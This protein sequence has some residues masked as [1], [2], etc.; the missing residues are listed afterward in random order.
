MNN[1]FKAFAGVVLTI[2]ALVGAAWAFDK[3]YTPREVMEMMVSDLQQN[4]M[5]SKKNI[6][7]QNAQQWLWFWQMK[8]EEYTAI[9]SRE[10]SNQEARR[11]LMEARQKRDEWQGRVNNLMSK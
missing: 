1:K 5:Q 7:V 10:P 9:C 3:K 2:S 8:V 6:Q 4:Q 11:K